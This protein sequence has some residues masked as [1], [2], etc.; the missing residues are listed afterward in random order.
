MLNAFSL[1][2]AT[3]VGV[4]ASLHMAVDWRNASCGTRLSPIKNGK[5]MSPCVW[6]NKSINWK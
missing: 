5:K 3:P 4:T 1:T 6:G 2:L